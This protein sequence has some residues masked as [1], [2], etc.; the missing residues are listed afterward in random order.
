[1]SHRDD[2]ENA[3]AEQDNEDRRVP[4]LKTLLERNTNKEKRV[5][6]DLRQIVDVLMEKMI[7]AR[8]LGLVMYV[9]LDNGAETGKPVL[10]GMRIEKRMVDYVNK[11]WQKEQQQGGR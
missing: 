6:E 10:T 8:A 5:I 1:M 2:M 7:E 9:S 11:E 4:D 3:V